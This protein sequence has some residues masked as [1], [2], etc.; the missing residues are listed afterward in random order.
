M[1]QRNTKYSVSCPRITCPSLHNRNTLKS[2]PSFPMKQSSFRAE[3]TAKP[4]PHQLHLECSTK[5]LAKSS[6]LWRCFLR[7]NFGPMRSDTHRAEDFTRCSVRMDR[8]VQRILFTAG[9]RLDRPA[10]SSFVGLLSSSSVGEAVPRQQPG[11]D[12]RS[13]TRDDSISRMETAASQTER[14]SRQ[15]TTRADK[16]RS[17]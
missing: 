16:M 8:N 7:T 14:R 9:H 17:R 6:S 15:E 13:S 4:T 1:R 11:L 5:L 2:N 10:M 3:T 12:D